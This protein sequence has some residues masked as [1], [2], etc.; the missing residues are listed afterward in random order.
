VA[1]KVV[2]CL[3]NSPL[4]EGLMAVYTHSLPYMALK[5]E[6]YNKDHPLEELKVVAYYHICEFLH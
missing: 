4:K 6:H 5:E 3:H 1:L 2:V